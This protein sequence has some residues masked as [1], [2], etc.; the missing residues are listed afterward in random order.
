VFLSTGFLPPLL[1]SS[2]LG[3]Q[4]FKACGPVNKLEIP[5][6]NQTLVMATSPELYH[7]DL[8]YAS[9]VQET[10]SDTVHDPRDVDDCKGKPTVDDMADTVHDPKDVDD[11][12]GKLTVDDMVETSFQPGVQDIEAVTI[13]WSRSALLGA[14]VLI[15]LI[16]FVQGLV[17]AVSGALLPYV[18]S[19]F[20]EHSLTA[21]TGV[22]SAVIGGVT[23][24]SLGKALDVFGRPQGFFVAVVLATIGLI[25]AAAC[26]NVEAYAASQVF[27]TVGIN[28]IGY[29][30]SVFLAD[31]TSLRNRALV[32]ALCNTPNVITAWLGGPIS[33]AFLNGAG[34]RWAF[35]MESVLVPAVSLPLLGLFTYYFRKAKNL[36]VV[37]RLASRRTLSQSL[38]YYMHEFDIIGLFLISAGVAFFLLP[39]NLYTMQAQGWGSALIICFLVFGIIL[40]IGFVIWERFF[41]QVS[42]LPWKLFR[43]R[44]VLGACFLS[45]VLFLSSS[46]WAAYFSSILQVVHDLNVTHASYVVQTYTVGCFFFAVITGAVISYTGF[47]KSIT[48]YFALPL[49]ILGSGLMVYFR[50]PDQNVG[51]IVM[52]QI[53]LSFSA[54]VIMVTDEIAMLAVVEEQQY[55]AVGIAIL[56]LF[57][58]IGSAIGLTISAAIWQNI[59]PNKLAL[60]LPPDDQPNLVAIYSDIV[61]QLSYPVGSPTRLAIQ[62]AY[63]DTQQYL[64]VA[65]TAIWVIGVV[66]VLM[67]R[68]INVIGIKQTKGHVF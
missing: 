54:G 49:G 46:C 8:K 63:G 36:G 20:A 57:G 47:Y 41:A 67:W 25:M 51:Y 64:F 39:F 12:K 16:Y 31:T 29:S 52:S 24:L 3:R 55:F 62:H 53:F 37:P 27:Y 66:S 2:E 11:Y 34:W 13:S 58:S 32:Q 5:T 33:I 45:T 60:Y 6:E 4:A 23:N 65:G 38:T 35:G 56:G 22:I 61:T 50:Q 1:S 44:T 7:H 9:H 10:V 59:L 14:Y 40:I 42:F 28:G 19:A 30:L 17:A 21:T 15:W 43:D 48:L 68:D 26:N 18:T